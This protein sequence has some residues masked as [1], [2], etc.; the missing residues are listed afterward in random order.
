MKSHYRIDLFENAGSKRIVI[1]SAS[2]YTIK[3]NPVTFFGRL[4]IDGGIPPGPEKVTDLK[5]P[6][7]RDKP[8]LQRLLPP[9]YHRIYFSYQN[10]HHLFVNLQK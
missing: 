7:T 5:I 2:K 3:A 9:F 4:Y 1:Y 8:D 10:L 6:T